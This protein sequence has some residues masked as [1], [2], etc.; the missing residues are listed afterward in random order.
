MAL[1]LTR[2]VGEKVRISTPDGEQIEVTLLSMP[3]RFQIQLGI[4]APQRYH[5]DRVDAFNQTER[6]SNKGRRRS[7]QPE[8]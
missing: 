7:R 2:R 3:S 6:R 1:Q 4:A 8:R 5:I